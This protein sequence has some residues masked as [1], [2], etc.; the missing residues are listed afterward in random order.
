M[1]GPALSTFRLLAAL[2]FGVVLLWALPSIAPAAPDNGLLVFGSNRD[3]GNPFR[4]VNIYTM[5]AD[6]SGVA[7]LTDQGGSEPAW[8][9][10][11]T[12]IAFTTQYK[13]DPSSWPL[14]VYHM[15]PDGSDKTLIIDADQ[16]LPLSSCNFNDQASWSPDGTKIALMMNG[17]S[18]NDQGVMGGIFA[19]D[20]ATGVKTRL[21]TNRTGFAIDQLPAWSHDGTKIA[22]TRADDAGVYQIY[23]MDADGGSLTQLTTA[24]ASSASP[25]WSPD[26]SKI[27]FDRFHDQNTELFVMDADGSDLTQVTD[28]GSPLGAT[29]THPAWSPDGSRIAFASNRAS[30]GT[31]DYEIYVMDADG[32]NVTQ[33]T[34]NTDLDLHPDWQPVDGAPP[35]PPPPPPPVPG[36]IGILEEAVP[37]D[38]Q[39]FSF[40]GSGAIG[41]FA[42]DDD[43]DPTLPKTRSFTGLVPG[44]YTIQQ[45]VPTG[46]NL[47]GLVCADPDNGSTVDLAT[48]TVTIDLDPGETVGCNFTNQPQPLTRVRIRVDAVPDD[49][50]DFSFTGSGAIGSFDLD[51]DLSGTL[52]ASRVFDLDPGSYTVQQTV[53]AGWDLTGLACDD[54]DSTTD[55]AT[56]TATIDLDPGETVTCTY[57][58]SP[59]PPPPPPPP[60]NGTLEVV[61][62]V[63]PDSD[64]DIPFN[65][66]S[67]SSLLESFDLDDDQDPTLPSSHARAASAG[68]YTVVQDRTLTNYDL[69][70]DCVDPDGG[71]TVANNG[72]TV[73]LDDGETVTCTFTSTKDTAPPTL[74]LPG[75]IAVDATIPSGAPVSYTASASDLV[76][77]SPTVSCVPASGSVFPI[78]RTTV[79]CTATDAAGNI[80]TGSF[81]IL[82]LGAVEQITVLDAKTALLVDNRGLEAALRASLR[83]TTIALAAG[84][85]RVACAAVTVYMAAVR[86]APSRMLTADEKQQLTADASRIRAVIG[87]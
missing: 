48:A 61:L 80:A 45:A 52:P 74:T 6:G 43:A 70:V 59:A 1:T 3:T 9:Q 66:F 57:T 27:V 47:S 30:G 55:L 81:S 78:G 53:P 15:N 54:A 2:G 23:V 42:L 8:S 41:P 17:C 29:S 10:D 71:T 33:I 36:N 77:R 13:Y 49:P 50:Q 18:L 44:T 20:V 65:I 24:A 76:D 4:P 63:V 51:D 72:A 85:K 79:N 7:Q 40:S 25:D 68:T 35:P 28:I 58:N 14:A 62:D 32:G 67:G 5:A 19:V 39:D 86:V 31:S 38:P 64:A 16:S 73:D 21:T 56:A 87:C 11:G 84:R 37:D 22:F 34:D 46:W 82:V 12:K 75:S 60:T 83:A 69:K 26:D